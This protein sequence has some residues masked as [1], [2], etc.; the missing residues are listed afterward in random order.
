MR[1]YSYH[2]LPPFDI[3]APEEIAHTYRRI[4]LSGGNVSQEEN[5][6]IWQKNHLEHPPVIGS[7]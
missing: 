5:A 3:L 1:E 6:D 2:D 7:A 4:I